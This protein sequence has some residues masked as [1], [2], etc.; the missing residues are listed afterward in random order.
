MKTYFVYD[1][2]TGDAYFVKAESAEGAC[3]KVIALLWDDLPPDQK[4]ATLDDYNKN[5]IGKLNTSIK[6]HHQWCLNQNERYPDMPIEVRPLE[7][8]PEYSEIDYR[9]ELAQSISVV[10]EVNLDREIIPIAD[11]GLCGYI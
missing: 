2:N 1:E 7:L 8:C 9:E 6:E 4:K 5:C 11:T 10:Q 3:A